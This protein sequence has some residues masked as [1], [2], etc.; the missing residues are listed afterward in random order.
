MKGHKKAF[1]PA[2]RMSLKVHGETGRNAAKIA[3][4]KHE[5]QGKT[6]TPHDVSDD[7][8]PERAFEQ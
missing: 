1:Q 8:E 3:S 2:A 6:G 4:P 5:R 7:D